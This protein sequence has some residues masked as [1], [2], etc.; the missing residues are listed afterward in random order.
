MNTTLKTEKNE[1]KD[2]ELLGLALFLNVITFFVIIFICA[3]F[4][5][6]IS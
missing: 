3:A 5:E 2:T 6:L 1:R 4:G